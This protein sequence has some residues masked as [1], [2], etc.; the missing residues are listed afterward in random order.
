MNFTFQQMLT[1]EAVVSQGSILAG[2][3]ILN[4][5]HPSVITALKKMEDALGFAIFDRSG[6]RCVL[7]EQGKAFHKSVKRIL[8]EMQELKHQAA[9]LRGGEEPELNIM[10]GDIT[11]LPSALAVLRGFSE[12]YSYTRLNLFFGNLF[13]PNESLLDGTVDLIIHHIDKADARYEYRDFC[14]VPIVPV[15]APGFFQMPIRPDLRYTEIT[16]YTQCIIRDTATHSEKL[17]R[18]VL[19]DSPHLTVG[20]Q[21]TKKEVIL[22]RMAWGHMPLFLVQEELNDGRLLSV[23]GEYVRGINREIVIARVAANK[24]GSMAQRLWQFFDGAG[25][26]LPPRPAYLPGKY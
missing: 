15:A 11:P 1:L 21:Y 23:E 4:K 25:D 12:T 6:Y 17:T 20:D 13:G 22:Q 26:F 5:T 14:S 10:V 7:T 24:H 2:A 8:G 18:F 19:N 3:K 9:S 16:D